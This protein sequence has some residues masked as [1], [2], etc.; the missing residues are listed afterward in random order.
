MFLT[1]GLRQLEVDRYL[2]F[3]PP[4][5]LTSAPMKLAVVQPTEGYGELIAHL[6]SHRL[7][8]CKFDVVSICWSSST[9][10]TWL[11]CH[12][13]QMMTIALTHRLWNG[14]DRISCAC[15]AGMV[16]V[17]DSISSGQRWFYC[18]AKLGRASANA[19][20]SV[21]ASALDSWPLTGSARCAQLA[22]APDR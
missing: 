21:W 5:A 16:I 4:E 9:N 14:N 20:S 22:R 3:R 7:Q 11:S 13:P 1:I 15:Y 17:C 2:E 18:M 6:S 12:K 19:D 8:L 10:Q